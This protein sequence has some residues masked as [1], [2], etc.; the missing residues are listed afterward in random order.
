MCPY[1]KRLPYFSKLSLLGRNRDKSQSHPGARVLWFVVRWNGAS[2]ST[3][4]Y[5]GA[6]SFTL[7]FLGKSPF[8]GFVPLWVLYPEASCHGEVWDGREVRV[9]STPGKTGMWERREARGTGRLRQLLGSIS[10]K[11]TSEKFTSLKVAASRSPLK[12][13]VLPGGV[14]VLH[15]RIQLLFWRV[16]SF[17]LLAQP[18]IPLSCLY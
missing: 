8:W 11:R 17:M 13:S 18:L 16:H 10:G 6:L 4:F 15:S 2:P 1:H 12:G 5:P 14:C 9:P 7:W 3:G